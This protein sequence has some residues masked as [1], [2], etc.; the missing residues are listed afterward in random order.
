MKKIMM[1]ICIV[2]PLFTFSAHASLFNPDLDID[3]NNADIDRIGG[4]ISELPKKTRVELEILVKNVVNSPDVKQ[5]SIAILESISNQFQCVNDRLLDGFGNV[6]SG[7]VIGKSKYSN[8]CIKKIGEKPKWIG[9]QSFN[10]LQR[11]KLEKCS[12]AEFANRNRERADFISNVRS[13]SQTL[14][15]L[16]AVIKCSSN[17]I[18]YP[19]IY[20]LEASDYYNSFDGIE[21][22]N[23]SCNSLQ[24]CN[25]KISLASQKRLKSFSSKWK[26]NNEIDIYNNELDLLDKKI[27]IFKE[28]KNNYDINIQL[29]WSI[30]E[31]YNIIRKINLKD[32]Y[33]LQKNIEMNNNMSDICVAIQR[34]DFPNKLKSNINK[35]F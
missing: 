35:I 28:Q 30:S 22:L 9:T 15:T 32:G 31:H 12:L 21:G 18:K 27:K 5:K 1:F 25:M 2:M 6:I 33:F 19:M 23:I 7:T 34:K 10:L 3:F 17:K 26:L 13:K 8:F 24:E 4:W 11:Y 20:L 14:K 29:L 16:G